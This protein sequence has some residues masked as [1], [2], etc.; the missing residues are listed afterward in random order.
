MVK[1]DYIN[2]CRVHDSKVQS[3]K[4]DNGKFAKKYLG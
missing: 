4:E 3:N 2:F 1:D